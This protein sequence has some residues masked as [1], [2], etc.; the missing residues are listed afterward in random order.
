MFMVDYSK[1]ISRMAMDS[2]EVHDG[3]DLALGALQH[4]DG[5]TSELPTPK[6]PTPFAND[7]DDFADSERDSED[8]LSFCEDLDH[9]DA[10]QEDEYTDDYDDDYS[11]SDYDTD[12]QRRVLQEGV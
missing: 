7:S 11:S 5:G 10:D 2:S 8:N 4:N 6:S 9:N 12:T 1:H 3:E